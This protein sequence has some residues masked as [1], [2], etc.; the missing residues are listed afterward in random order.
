MTVHNDLKQA[1]NKIIINMGE[2]FEEHDNILH[3]I[4]DSL[5]DKGFSDDIDSM[6]I[7]QTIDIITKEL[8]LI[9]SNLHYQSSIESVIA[10]GLRDFFITPKTT[11]SEA[12]CLYAKNYNITGDF[13]EVINHVVTEM[14]EP[15][16]KANTDMTI[17]DAIIFIGESAAKKPA[18]D[19]QMEYFY[20][21]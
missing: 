18:G 21:H 14:V 10:N 4:I 20:S 2:T 5:E 12:A 7:K 17:R 11:I 15:V 13:D 16:I 1:I 6:G 19:W 8:K 3:F 9:C